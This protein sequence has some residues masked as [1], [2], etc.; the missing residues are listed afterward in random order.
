MRN[1][2][3][4]QFVV[5]IVAL[6]VIL[7]CVA[8]FCSAATPE[9]IQRAI[10]AA[11]AELRPPSAGRTPTPPVGSEA[12]PPLAEN[13]QDTASVRRPA[14]VLTE[15]DLLPDQM[16]TPM[17]GIGAA[18]RT[19]NVRGKTFVDVGCGFDC[20]AGI[21]AVRDFGAARVLA[22]EIDPI[23]ATSARAYVEAAGLQG[24]IKVVCKDAADVEFPAGAVGFGYLWPETLQA[25]APK[26]AKLDQFA[27]YSHAIPGLQSQQV[28]DVFVYS[29]P[30]PVQF[31][32]VPVYAT[33]RGS[34][35]W[36]GR[37][38]SHPVCNRPGC[39][40][41]AAI[42]SQLASTSRQ[43]VGYKTVPV[44]A[45]TPAPQQAAPRTRTVM[46]KQCFIDSRGRKQCRMVPVTVSY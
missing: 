9:E 22:I 37:Q 19:L 26:I 27:S 44:Q 2:R 15:A 35:T 21:V 5:G 39:S 36:N 10:A 34:A 4:F 8:S 25:L 40:M 33:V 13:A 32:Q 16:P 3:I 29:K 1:A 28:G 45:A 30:A 41:C 18:L 7:G 42:R 24:R 23:I 6:L 43:V 20:R 14:G 31:K 12:S 46:Q 38:Y 17:E 11:K